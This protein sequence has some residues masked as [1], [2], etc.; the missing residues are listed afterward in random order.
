[1]PA[2]A[3]VESG[4]SSVSVAALRRLASTQLRPAAPRRLAA[5]QSRPQQPLRLAAAQSRR[6]AR[7]LRQ[8][9]RSRPAPAAA[10]SSA[11]HDLLGPPRRARAAL[12]GPHARAS[13]TT[14]TLA[15]CRHR[16]RRR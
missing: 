15:C 6:S 3:L 7:D 9:R 5:A 16:R 11:V 1:V 14:L 12:T 8:P 10:P 2:P 4:H 13:T